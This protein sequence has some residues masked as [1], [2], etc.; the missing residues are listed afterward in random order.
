MLILSPQWFT[1]EGIQKEEAAA[2]IS[3]D[4]F[5]E[6][7]R[8][9]KISEKSKDIFA[10]RTL[11]ILIGS[12][13]TK[14]TYDSLK[15]IYDK[16]QKKGLKDRILLTAENYKSQWHYKK[17]I[18]EELR[19]KDTSGFKQEET[20]PELPAKEEMLKEAAGRAGI[21]SSN[22]TYEVQNDYF[23]EYMKPRLSSLK[24]SQKDVDYSESVEYEDLKL[25]IK[26]AKEQN[27][28]IKLVSIPL[29]GKWSDYTGFS[30]EKRERY[31]E[32]IRILAKDEKVE[33]LDYSD[34]EYDPY[35]LKDIMHVGEKGWVY[36]DEEIQKFHNQ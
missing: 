36:I 32:N 8:N 25:F 20:N 17:H 18:L 5:E 4:I 14:K 10:K 29:H 6:V 1:K 27:I 15:R 30:K 21:K 12:E 26:M 11:S 24:D 35:F 9:K 7:L 2:F 16:Y 28:D 13:E 23:N 19:G 31:Y 22:N 34:H 3:P 33:L